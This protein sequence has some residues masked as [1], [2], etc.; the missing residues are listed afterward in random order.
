MWQQDLHKLLLF[1]IKNLKSY[2]ALIGSTV[3]IDCVLDNDFTLKYILNK[4]SEEI[5]HRKK[6]DKMLSFVFDNCSEEEIASLEYVQDGSI[7]LL[8]IDS[9]TY[10][11]QINRLGSSFGFLVNSKKSNLC[12][13]LFD[14]FI[15]KRGNRENSS[16]RVKGM[17]RYC[18]N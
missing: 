9:S 8:D 13:S 7:D 16:S 4:N 10:D 17:E 1:R 2:D 12:K 6:P 15:N 18:I 14:R 5:G 3:K 11:L